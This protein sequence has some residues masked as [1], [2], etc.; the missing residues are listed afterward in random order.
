MIL[1]KRII[2]IVIFLAGVA[3]IAISMYITDQVNAGKT[4][5][6]DAQQQ[7]NQGKSL[8]SQSPATKPVGDILTKSAQ[9]KIDAGK[10]EVS[11]YEK[12]ASNLKITGIV[13]LIAGVGVVLIGNKKK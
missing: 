4:Q 1:I 3:L 2:G 12:L 9:K 6:S 8:F 7:V 5:I 11:E 13:L 10:E